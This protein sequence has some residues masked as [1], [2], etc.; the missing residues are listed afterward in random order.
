M[1]TK[2]TGLVV[3]AVIAGGLALTRTKSAA[4]SDLRDAVGEQFAEFDTNIPK[5]GAVQADIPEP[6]LK[7]V[8]QAAAGGMNTVTDSVFRREQ[9][10]SSPEVSYYGV[11]FG[12][13]AG[14]PSEAAAGESF[15][16]WKGLH[17]K[18]GIKIDAAHSGVEV[19]RWDNVVDGE[20]Y[21]SPY[22]LYRNSIRSTALKYGFRIYYE[23]AKARSIR[24]LEVFS[25]QDR[26]FD[27]AEAA[28]AEMQKYL[29]IFKK[30]GFSIP[31]YAVSDMQGKYGFH[32]YYV[33]ERSLE[34]WTPSRIDLLEL[35][36]DCSGGL[37]KSA[38]LE[39]V[40]QA[41]SGKG[42]EILYL[43]SGDEPSVLY[44]RPNPAK[45]DNKSF[46]T[47]TSSSKL[48]ITSSEKREEMYGKLS[49]KVKKLTEDKAVV[50][51]CRV[52]PAARADLDLVPKWV[53]MWTFEIAY[54]K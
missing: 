44:I 51:S 47:E 46:I 31:F 25:G 26:L 53:Q 40:R 33:E 28:K 39:R 43:N 24:Y 14:F 16:F 41:L 17:E 6:E 37:D 18:A 22:Y 48:L 11:E 30:H 1:K 7:K 8:G 29:E 21:H 38:Y 4:P 32:I 9:L 42:A 52:S 50:V 12:K 5:V 15:A 34:S 23:A 49:E 10:P 13:W 54:I 3:L 20:V 45:A 36:Y 2:I 35:D 19:Y 27:G